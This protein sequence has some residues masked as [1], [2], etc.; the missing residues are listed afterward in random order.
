[1][2]ELRQNFGKRLRYLRRIRDLTQ[3]QLAEGIG[4]SVNFVSLL[5]QG[6]TAPSFETLQELAL[7]IEVKELF[8]FSPTQALKENVIRQHPQEEKEA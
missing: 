1:M 2:S 6:R 3:E 8:D 5:E 4:R 7:E